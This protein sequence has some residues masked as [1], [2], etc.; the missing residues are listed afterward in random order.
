MSESLWNGPLY[1]YNAYVDNQPGEPLEPPAVSHAAARRPTKANSS[2][3]MT[4]ATRFKS[5]PT[6]L[7]AIDI[8][9]L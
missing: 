8:H 9:S 3:C 2:R 1:G 4:T 6:L 5:R 7:P